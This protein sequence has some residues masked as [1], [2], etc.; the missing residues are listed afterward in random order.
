[1]VEAVI[2]VDPINKIYEIV[3]TDNMKRRTLFSKIEGLNTDFPFFIKETEFEI[4]LLTFKAQSDNYILEFVVK[5]FQSELITDQAKTAVNVQPT[6]ESKPQVP[7]N[8]NI[9]LTGEAKK[10]REI[11]KLKI[12][13]N[14]IAIE[15]IKKKTIIKDKSKQNT[16]KK[17]GL[18]GRKLNGKLQDQLLQ[19]KNQLLK[20]N[21]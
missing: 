3:G 13:K 11:L 20:I 1:M 21:G 16:L 5:N 12:P 2:M 14:P 8:T 17:E 18:K 10:A 19:L 6:P 7:S 9:L 15:P 4:R